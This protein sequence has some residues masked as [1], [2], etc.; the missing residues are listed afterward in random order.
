MYIEEINKIIEIILDKFK[1]LW[2]DKR[3][4]KI[5]SLDFFLKESNF[6]KYQNEFNNIFV[7]VDKIIP[8]EKINKLVTKN[9]NVLLIKNYIM[10]AVA[11][12]IFII[13]GSLYKEK[14]YL[15][16]N[17]IVE[18][19][20]NQIKFDYKIDNFFNSE[21]NAHI[22]NSIVLFKDFL[23][24][25]DKVDP[26]NDITKVLNTFSIELQDLINSYG[27]EKNTKVSS[28]IKLIEKIDEYLLH[29]EIGK[30]ILFSFLSKENIDLEKNIEQTEL[31]SG[32]F[33]YIDVVLPKN[34][35]LVDF[36][37]IEK[38][39]LP[40]EIKKGMSD[41]I[42]NLLNYDNLDVIAQNTKHFMD[43]DAKIQKLFNSKIIVPIVDDF[44]LYHKDSERYESTKEKNKQ[45]TRLKY[46]T[47]KINKA[48]DYYSNPESNEKL[49]SSTLKD[50]NAVLINVIENVKILNNAMQIG[51]NSPSNELQDII[52]DLITYRM[53]P[54]IS[55]KDFDGNG[56]NYISI[57]P[58]QAVRKI[59]F[60]TSNVL[61]TRMI[62]DSIIANIVGIIILNS[63]DIVECLNTNDLIDI[64]TLNKKNPLENIRNLIYDRIINLKSDIKG[65]Y[66]WFFDLEHDKFT[67]PNYNLSSDMPQNEVLRY[68]LCYLY[69]IT[70]ESIF[71]LLYNNINKNKSQMISFNN[72]L[73]ND[74]KRKYDDMNA[75][76]F[77][78]KV[79]ELMY[80]IFYKKSIT[81][82]NIYDDNEDLFLGLSNSIKLPSVKKTVNKTPII[83]IN[84]KIKKIEKDN[85]EDNLQLDNDYLNED[86]ITE[87]DVNMQ[88]NAICQHI[89]SRNQIEM[90]K[91]TNNKLYNILIQEF[92]NNYVE[93]NIVNDELICKSCNSTIDIESYVI[94]GTFDNQTHKFQTYSVKIDMELDDIPDYHN[95]KYSINQIDIIVDYIAG[96]LKISQYTGI[97]NRSNRKIIVKNVLDFAINNHIVFKKYATGKFIESFSEKFGINTSLSNF[98]IFELDNNIFKKSSKETIDTYK[99]TKYNNIIAY[100]VINLLIEFNPIILLNIEANDKYVS[101]ELFTKYMK[102][103]FK[104]LKIIINKNGDTDLIINYPVLCFIIYT[105]TGFLAK[106]NKWVNLSSKITSKKFDPLVFKT[107]Q[108]SAINTIVV[109]INALLSA[110]IEYTNKEKLFI[111][112]SFNTKYYNNLESFYKNP[113][114]IQNL[115]DKYLAEKKKKDIIKKS[116]EID[117]FNLIASKI[118]R[119]YPDKQFYTALRVDRYLVPRN[120]KGITLSKL[121]NLTN[122]PDGNYHKFIYDNKKIICKL[123]NQQSGFKLYDEKSITKIEDLT[124]KKYLNKLTTKYCIDGN[125]HMFVNDICKKCQYDKYHPSNF[126]EKDLINL[127]EIIENKKNINNNKIKKLLEQN[128]N[129]DKE[130]FNNV[131][132]ILDKIMYKYQKY[133]SNIEKIINEFLDVI[134]QLIGEQILLNNELHHLTNDIFIIDH[135]I[136]GNKLDAK[137][138]IN[139]SKL[140]INEDHPFFKRSVYIYNTTFKNTKYEV[141]YD[142]N[143]KFL[144]GNRETNKEFNILNKLDAKLF[145]IASIKNILL[146]FGFHKNI[147]SHKDIFTE[148][149]ENNDFTIDQQV[150]INRCINYR[151]SYVKKL[152]VELN[153]YIN[154]LKNKF[155][156]QLVMVDV[157]K[158]KDNSD[159]NNLIVDTFNNSELDILYDKYTSKIEN[160]IKLTS[161]NHVFLKHFNTLYNFMD[162]KTIKV[163]DKEK[164]SVHSDTLIKNDDIGNMIFTYILDEILRLIR[165][166]DNK[167]IKTNLISYILEIINVIYMNSNIDFKYYSKNI[168]H[169]VQSLYSSEFFLETSYLPT[170]DFIE[171]YGIEEIKPPENDEAVTKK[172]NKKDDDDEEKDALDVDKFRDEDDNED[173]DEGEYVN[174]DYIR[175]D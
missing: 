163:K 10:K 122:C 119:N 128:K 98:F 175:D 142:F 131:K 95:F 55:F 86:I 100:I 40:N 168:I 58:T 134:Q 47:N 112:D 152:G 20:K 6:V 59:S 28:Y 52:S 133:D 156:S 150:F 132:N 153:K 105:F 17:N 93:R 155:K 71:D 27:I 115:N 26:K 80:L 129:Y 107:V 94:E 24:F 43:Y 14:I 170:P 121:S 38:L 45:D 62:N 82:K 74:F 79:N 18:I 65:N 12:Y 30:T 144:L 88:T 15:F 111:Y 7:Y 2:Y 116:L 72:E 75:P 101:Y 5:K 46:I 149:Y 49:F 126:K 169:F 67:I 99:L 172:Q 162:Y 89:I 21:T 114:I 97:F 11:Y 91:T 154:R 34:E 92:I 73:F 87:N 23:K 158:Y 70:I 96:I 8:I 1:D 124:F 64:K 41:N 135:D 66:Y 9:E 68:T 53:Y 147:I 4:E 63:D 33:I 106:Y 157:D 165:Y 61:Q 171:Y 148:L 141:F 166:N 54:Y 113:V 81:P 90:V 160:N 44:L 3:S 125:I 57:D 174:D 83:N 118:T 13:I 25:L 110:D 151:F 56:F 39:L 102:D 36:S 22:I 104:N 145:N 108:L 127:H 42:Y 167:N 164:E 103:I 161:E 37:D 159:S 109:I 173:N 32:E 137:V 139:D 60:S 143:D 31:Q 76:N 138:Q 35:N 117:K 50:R 48:T 140:R 29:H 84:S 85:K 123:C 78:S 77:E 69:D 16:N 120:N 136:F 51:K 146:T 130:Q 19:S